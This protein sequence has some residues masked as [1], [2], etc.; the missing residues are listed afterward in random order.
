M[1]IGWLVMLSTLPKPYVS[2]M[3]VTTTVMFHGPVTVG[4]VTI[5]LVT[6]PEIACVVITRVM[7]VGIS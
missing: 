7:P 1:E 6:G 5:T 3:I 2:S 4:A